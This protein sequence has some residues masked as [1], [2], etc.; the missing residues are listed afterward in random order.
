MSQK[1]LY[2]HDRSLRSEYHI[3]QHL[4]HNM[5]VMTVPNYH[6]HTNACVI[7]IVQ[8]VPG[9][10]L[11]DVASKCVKAHLITVVNSISAFINI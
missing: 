2:T 7:I 3:H 10:T 6:D 8:S 11:T 4:H 5:R 1:C 9:L